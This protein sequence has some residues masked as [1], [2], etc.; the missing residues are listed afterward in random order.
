MENKQTSKPILEEY[1]PGKKPKRGDPTS[2]IKDVLTEII[3][4][5][6]NWSESHRKLLIRTIHEAYKIYPEDMDKQLEFLH[7][8]LEQ[9]LGKRIQ[10]VIY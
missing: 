7:F 4:K 3:H 1:I 10:I 6:G 9:D 5:E 2:S 8:N